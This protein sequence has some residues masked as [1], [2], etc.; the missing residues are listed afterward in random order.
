MLPP[1]HFLFTVALLLISLCVRAQNE[2]QQQEAHDVETCGTRGHACNDASPDNA[3]EL[4]LLQKSIALQTTAGELV[5]A[6]SP[7]PKRHSVA[8][9]GSERKSSELASTFCLAAAL[10]RE[11]KLLKI[12]V[13][14]GMLAG[15]TAWSVYSNQSMHELCPTCSSS[16]NFVDVG[17]IISGPMLVGK[18]EKGY[19]A[20][21][22]LFQKIWK[23]VAESRIFD[24]YDWI[25][26]LDLDT[27]FNPRR[28]QLLVSRFPQDETVA[29]AN[30]KGSDRCFT[31]P[32]EVLS[33]ATVA[34]YADNREDCER[35]GA[36]QRSLQED[37]YMGA[38]IVRVLN[39]RMIPGPHYSLLSRPRIEPSSEVEPRGAS[40][41]CVRACTETAAIAVHPCKD[42]GSLSA[43]GSAYQDHV[44]DGSSQHGQ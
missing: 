6:W 7:G 26:K 42:E 11:A 38:C 37:W 28:L 23:H 30:C 8:F 43:C 41:E 20:N 29:F 16:Q 19:W 5:S 14:K 36:E 34:K 39:V 27:A 15:C 22:H 2:S 33:K 32:L 3:D 12:H 9:H 4:L 35:M 10:P 17:P 44:L 25:V 13:E 18:D 40:R 1:S 24:K 31:G 21:T